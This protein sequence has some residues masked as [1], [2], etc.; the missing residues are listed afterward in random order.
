MNIKLGELLLG[1]NLISEAQL[2]KALEA[3]R[4][5]GGKLGTNLVELGFVSDKNLVSL[6]S[7]Q[8][9]MNAATTHDFES[10]PLDALKIVEKDYAVANNIIP[11]KLD[12]KLRVAV[13]DPSV[14][15]ELDSLSFRIGRSIQ[16]VIAPEIWIVAALER[17]YGHR[18][19]TRYL[20]VDSSISKV[21]EALEPILTLE[22]QVR[23]VVSP[24]QFVESLLAAESVKDVFHALLDFLTPVFS[25]M[26]LYSIKGET[27]SG[28]MLHGFPIHEKTFVEMKL[29]WADSPILTELIEKKRSFVADVM[30]LEIIPALLPL[31]ISP[32]KK[33]SLYPV[34]FQ[35]SVICILAGVVEDD[36]A[37]SEKNSDTFIVD[38]IRR[39][40]HAMEYVQAKKKVRNK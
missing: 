36:Q 12:A 28:I 4:Q 35:E 22:Q 26:A 11:L 13:S 40:G 33:T 2:E 23:K 32:G 7:Q 19:E 1:A 24:T 5:F 9:N 38:A 3:Q 16:P 14:L 27:M 25:Q 6:L 30:S 17:F 15:L 37:T 8:L 10:I 20:S 31:N 39:I 18:R 34:F 21:A 29:T